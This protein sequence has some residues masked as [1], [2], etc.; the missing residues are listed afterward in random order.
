MRSLQIWD[1]QFPRVFVIWDLA[2]LHCSRASVYIVF[3]CCL[4]SSPIVMR[5]LAIL[6]HSIK[7]QTTHDHGPLTQPLISA[8]IGLEQ[9]RYS[10]Q[11]TRF[12]RF[13]VFL[14]LREGFRTSTIIYHMYHLITSERIAQN[15]QGFSL[16][17]P[18][19]KQVCKP[20]SMTFSSTQTIYI[21]LYT[22]LYRVS[23]SYCLC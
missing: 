17:Y 9:E 20:K 13:R 22:L 8:K 6:N 16:R 15:Q 1:V 7:T 11:G 12:V 14:L 2:Y 18:G 3:P 10:Y 4:V 19:K 23:I 5:C 21:V